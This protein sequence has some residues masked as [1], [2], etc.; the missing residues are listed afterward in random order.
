MIAFC[1][2][3]KHI[4]FTLS[5]KKVRSWLESKTPIELDKNLKQYKVLRVFFIILIT[6]VLAG[7]ITQAI[8]DF[9]DINISSVISQIFAFS[10]VFTLVFMIL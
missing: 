6:I 4:Y 5:L 8:L 1:I 7:S 9:F 2:L 3:V 10:F